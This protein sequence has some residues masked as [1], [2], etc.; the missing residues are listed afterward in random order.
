MIS[1]SAESRVTTKSDVLNDTQAIAAYVMHFRQLSWQIQQLSVVHLQVSD[2]YR[3]SSEK[4]KLMTN[5]R[6]Q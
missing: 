2:V 4:Y 6:R 1:E 5:I 3:R